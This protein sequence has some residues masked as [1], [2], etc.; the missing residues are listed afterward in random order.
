MSPCR[1]Q[2]VLLAPLQVDI[3]DD[4]VLKEF[5]LTRAAMAEFMPLSPASASL[6]ELSLVEPGSAPVA[7]SESVGILSP[8]QGAGAELSSSPPSDV[9][10]GRVEGDH[11][12]MWEV[13]GCS[14]HCPGHVYGACDR[15]WH[16]SRTCEPC[17]AAPLPQEISRFLRNPYK[18]AILAMSRPD[19]K[20]N[21][22]TLVKVGS[23]IHRA[24]LLCLRA[25]KRSDQ[26]PSR[27]SACT[28]VC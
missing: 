4:P 13:S 19:A 9:A 16:A 23:G 17:C 22:T 26:S 5:E 21:I 14:Y 3:P 6:N 18:P 24:C 1:L 27:V 10:F 7:A 25:W 20:K 2:R 12:R 28:E 8:R 11:P 15:S